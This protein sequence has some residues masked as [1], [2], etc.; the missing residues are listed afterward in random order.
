MAMLDALNLRG[1][2]GANF[3]PSTYS[4]IRTWLLNGTAVNMAYMLSVQLATMELNV[5]SGKVNAGALIYA[6]GTNSANAAG[7]ATVGAVMAEANT[8][9][10]TN[11][12]T[13][14]GS[15]V[16][17]YQE[18]LKN[19]L[20]NA[21]NNKTFVQPDAAHCPVPVFTPYVPAN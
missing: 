10:G 21:N 5:A 6:P 3:D 11:G 8:S 13:P 12:Y 2:T 16:R 15:S 17:T 19:A 18:A 4:Q 14:S 7:Y 20:D 9:L 1:A